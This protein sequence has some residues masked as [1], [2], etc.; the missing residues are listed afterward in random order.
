MRFLLTLCA[1]LVLALTASADTIVTTD[2]KSYTR[3]ADGHYYPTAH[4]TPGGAVVTQ[5][6]TVRPAVYAVPMTVP[7]YRPSYAP[8]H[9]P[10]YP[11]AQPGC[12]NGRCPMPVK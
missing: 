1:L 2:G 8:Q 6:P 10:A 3:A 4:V 12:A 11:F 9:L 5:V 7:S